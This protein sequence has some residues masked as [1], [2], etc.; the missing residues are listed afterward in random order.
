[1]SAHA[2]YGLPES[3]SIKGNYVSTIAVAANGVITI[4]YKSSGLGGSPTANDGTIVLEPSSANPGSMTWVCD[5]SG[6][7]TAGNMPSKY[8][9]SECRP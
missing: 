3:D 6:V 7:A 1:M 2:S 8:R 5:D 9:P 4:S